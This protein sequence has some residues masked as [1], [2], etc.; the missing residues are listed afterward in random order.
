HIGSYQ[1]TTATGYR[2]NIDRYQAKNCRGCQLR[3]LCHKAKGNRIV[4]RNHKLIRLKAKAKKKL[5][6]PEGIAHRK[7][8]CWDVEAV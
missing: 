3:P 5:L 6:S 1:R 7:Q 4:E 2:Q 8:R